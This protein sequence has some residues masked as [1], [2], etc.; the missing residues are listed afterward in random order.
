MLDALLNLGFENEDID[1][2]GFQADI[3]RN[4]EYFNKAVAEYKLLL[5]EKEDN[6]T[7]DPTMDRLEQNKYREYYSM[8]RI[9][10][11]GLVST[12]DFKISQL[13]SKQNG[14]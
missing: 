13:E 12:L 8:M 9:L 5:M 7:A 6:I 2:D 14:E 4:N 1:R 3:L 11:D 10:L